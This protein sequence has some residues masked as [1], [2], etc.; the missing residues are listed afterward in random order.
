[1]TKCLKMALYFILVGARVINVMSAF[2][3]LL[4]YT[5]RF[6]KIDVKPNIT[7]DYYSIDRYKD[8]QYVN[9]QITIDSK[10]IIDNVV[11][12]FY[13]CD[14]DGI[15]CEYFQTWKIKDVCPKLLQKNQMWSRWYE[16]FHPPLVCPVDKVHYKVKNATV[17][18]GPLAL[19]YPQVT[20]YQWKVIQ[21]F[22][23]NDIFVGSYTIEASIF[24][25]RKKIKSIFTDN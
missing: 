2:N 24:G 4:T 10:E 12:I 17:D 16:S 23:A 1:M 8:V 6:K 5:V 18:V 25:Y 19:I 15:N 14:P 22:Y 7:L 20:D 21:K 3:P 9:G 11:G 13:R